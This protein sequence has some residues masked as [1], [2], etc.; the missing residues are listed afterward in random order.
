MAKASV[1]KVLLLGNLTREVDLRYTQAGK[2]VAELS[3]ALNRRNGEHEEVCFVDV[4]VWGKTAENCK[5]YLC[6][7]SCIYIEGYLRQ[8]R[9]EDRQS[10]KSRSKLR[11][12]AENVQFIS[13]PGGGTTRATDPDPGNSSRIPDDCAPPP[14]PRPRFYGDPSAGTPSKT[15]SSKGTAAS[16]AAH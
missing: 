14:A 16:A 5:H 4:V 11:V 10:G 2:P 12:V 6:K 1:N 13:Q 7:G 9:R 15:G 3:L 8:D